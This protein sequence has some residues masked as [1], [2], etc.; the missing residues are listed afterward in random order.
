MK[1]TT[2]ALC[3]GFFMDM[4]F[5]ALVAPESI[6]RD[7]LKWKQYFRD[8]FGCVAALRSP[9]HITLIPPFRMDKGSEGHLTEQM[10]EFS[11]LRGSFEIRLQNFS[12]FKPRVIFIGVEENETL[13]E[14]A[15]SF[16]QFLCLPG[17]DPVGKED[18]PFHPHVT[19]ATRD[20]RKKAFYEAWE[21]FSPKKYRATWT[22]EGISVLKHNG[23]H[24]DVIST[25]A[26]KG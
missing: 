14:L 10:N 1:K 21:M 4:Y 25:S 9:A 13:Q 7:V 17:T 3:C 6:N 20:I 24:W 8:R 22:V 19:L 12:C 16:R 26:F 15:A 11:L 2:V 23:R 5:L 18:R